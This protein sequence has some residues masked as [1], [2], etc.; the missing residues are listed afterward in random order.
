M[1]EFPDK[2]YKTVVIDP[3]WDLTPVFTSSFGMTNFKFKDSLPYETMSEEDLK[4]FRLIN[5]LKKNVSCFYGLLTP[6]FLKL[7]NLSSIGVLSITVF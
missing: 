2:K 1:L 6:L 7:W 3:P 5:L 4:D